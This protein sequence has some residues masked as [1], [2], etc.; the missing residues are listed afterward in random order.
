MS[1]RMSD[2]LLNDSIPAGCDN[3]YSATED[4][5]MFFVE[6]SS[7]GKILPN[8]KK[9]KAGEE[10]KLPYINL[11]GTLLNNT[12]PVHPVVVEIINTL[13]ETLVQYKRLSS[14][15][16]VKNYLDAYKL[17][18]GAYKDKNF[19]HHVLI[20]KWTDLNRKQLDIIKKDDDFTYAEPLFVR[21][22]FEF[23]CLEEDEILFLP[24][25]VKLGVMAIDSSLTKVGAAI[26]FPKYPLLF[27][28]TDF[29]RCECGG[30]KA[31]TTH[32]NWC[33]KY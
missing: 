16:K 10:I 31:N 7:S 22:S 32:S 17:V 9:I 25:S 2:V 8:T 15:Y 14:N 30:E 11:N 18:K 5:E 12:G 27:K 1:G 26:L 13:I 21:R 20:K 6:Q 3:S 4:D 23:D 24:S 28:V 29:A 19:I 33:P